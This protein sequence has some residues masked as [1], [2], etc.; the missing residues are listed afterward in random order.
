MFIPGR[1]CLPTL[2]HHLRIMC[3]TPKRKIENPKTAYIS[4]DTAPY[5]NRESSETPS[6]AS[7]C[8]VQVVNSGQFGSSPWA[9]LSVA[10][11]VSH[12]FPAGPKRH[13]THHHHS[14]LLKWLELISLRASSAPWRLIQQLASFVDA[15]LG[16]S[17][18]MGCPVSSPKSP[19]RFHRR[20]TSTRDMSSNKL[21]NGGQ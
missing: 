21:T 4:Y 2:H 14:N 18:I 7:P 8:H 6:T 10:A 11:P 5:W 20:P 17:P 15:L 19:S 12:T 9:I 16:H 1:C 3:V 13:V